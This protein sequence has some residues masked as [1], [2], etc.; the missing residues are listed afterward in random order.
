M[1]A[2]VPWS[3]V[4]NFFQNLPRYQFNLRLNILFGSCFL[5]LPLQK[6]IIEE[7]VWLLGDR[8]F[9]IINFNGTIRVTIFLAT[10]AFKQ[11]RFTPSFFSENYYWKSLL[12]NPYF[13][14]TSSLT[15]AILFRLNVLYSIF[16]S[17]FSFS[18]IYVLIHIYL[19]DVAY[20]WFQQTFLRVFA[21]YVKIRSVSYL[22][23]LSGYAEL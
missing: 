11:C 13:L 20:F 15:T 18:C 23:C 17:I 1:Y 3:S 5:L 12:Q 6:C 4:Y 8:H 9:C 10:I 21:E 7:V 22:Q 2:S 14:W 19:H 16:I